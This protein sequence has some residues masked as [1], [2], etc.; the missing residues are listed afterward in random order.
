MAELTPERKII[1]GRRISIGM[2]IGIILI[3]AATIPFLILTWTAA[4]NE[5]TRHIYWIDQGETKHAEITKELS[6]RGKNLY[7][8]T[9]DGED[10]IINQKTT[11]HI[12]LN[13]EDKRA[14][15]LLKE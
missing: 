6:T 9:I 15:A 11:R 2:I 8:E 10:I 14:E 5:N 12:I 7:V 13:F 3:Y 4:K 1:I